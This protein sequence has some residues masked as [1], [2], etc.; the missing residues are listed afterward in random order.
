MSELNPCPFCKRKAHLLV[1]L[2]RIWR[3]E[4]YHT[5]LCPLYSPFLGSHMVSREYSSKEITVRRWNAAK[6]QAQ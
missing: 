1:R 4:I 6:E 2:R 3:I 5:K